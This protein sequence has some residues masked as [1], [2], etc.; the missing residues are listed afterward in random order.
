MPTDASLIIDAAISI[1]SVTVLIELFCDIA[2]NEKLNIE[3]GI[4]SVGIVMVSA[5]STGVSGR[6]RMF[7][8]C[9][10]ANCT[11]QLF[12][13]VELSIDNSNTSVASPKF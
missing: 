3:S 10:Q 11:P 1:T 4:A 2:V 13:R 5:T 9:V 8:S 12:G 7:G 6:T